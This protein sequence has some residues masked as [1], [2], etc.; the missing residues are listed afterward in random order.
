MSVCGC[1]GV[2]VGVSGRVSVCTWYDTQCARVCAL[3]QVSVCAPEVRGRGT[4]VVCVCSV[5]LALCPCYCYSLLALIFHSPT[6]AITNQ[7]IGVPL[8][9]VKNTRA[10]SS[11]IEHPTLF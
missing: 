8:V 1:V 4:Q 7:I 6:T 2:C 11:T 5:V 10:I 3:R 9:I